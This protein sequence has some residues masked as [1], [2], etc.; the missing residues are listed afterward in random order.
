MNISEDM[1]PIWKIIHFFIV[2]PPPPPTRFKIQR[3]YF[4][5]LWYIYNLLENRN[6][7]FYSIKCSKCVI[8]TM[9][10]VLSPLVAV[11]VESWPLTLWGSKCVITIHHRLTLYYPNSD[12][13]FISHA[14]GSIWSYLSYYRSVHALP[15]NRFW[16]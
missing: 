13:G 5:Q 4:Y 6:R 3:M 2:N 14:F 15:L 1:L 7:S 12:F 10:G 9:S 8:L 11:G 16:I